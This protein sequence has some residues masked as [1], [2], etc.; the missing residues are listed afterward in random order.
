MLIVWAAVAVAEHRAVWFEVAAGTLF[1]TRADLVVYAAALLLVTPA[2]YRRIIVSVVTATAVV[3]PWLVVSWL[4]LGSLVPDTLVIKRGQSWGPWTFANGLEL[5]HDTYPLATV[6]SLVAPALGMVSAL[7]LA[8]LLPQLQ[9]SGLRVS[10]ALGLAVGAG[11]YYAVYSLLGVP[12]Y[13]WYY[14]TVIGVLTVVASAGLAS[15]VSLSPLPRPAT[16]FAVGVI[17]L[18]PLVMGG[19][20]LS[21]VARGQTQGSAAITTN[22]ASPADYAAAGE[23][24]GAL[25][26]GQVVRSPGEIGTLVYYCECTMVDAFSDR[27]RATE[28]I[29]GAVA[30]SG[31]LLQ[32]VWGANSRHLDRDAPPLPAALVVDWAAGPPPPEAQPAGVLGAWATTSPWRGDGHLVLWEP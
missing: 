15:A 22:W 7:V 14:G 16:G 24:I 12:P 10:P 19:V 30:S 21:A 20:V 2:M 1:L 26:G 17:A 18:V 25:A 13:H 23:R 9:R 31:P 28:L 27:G 32:R 3:T 4:T 11:G 5:N 29:D 8:M 6:A